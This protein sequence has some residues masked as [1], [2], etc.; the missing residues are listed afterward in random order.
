MTDW[1][2]LCLAVSIVNATCLRWGILFLGEPIVLGALLGLFLNNFTTGLYLGGIL[3]FMWLKS[4]PVGVKVQS[5][6]TVMTFLT[7][8][9]IGRFGERS[10]P[11][12]F[13]AAFAFSFLGK[14][15][16]TL[17]RRL[18]N[19]LADRVM[20]NIGRVN[21][22]LVNAVYLAGYVLV[23]AG[24]LFAGLSVSVPLVNWGLHWLPPKLLD[25]FQFSYPYLVLY[26]LSLFFQAV[27]L[28]GKLVYF[29]LGIAAGLCLMAF[30]FSMITNINVLVLLAAALSLINSKLVQFTGRKNAS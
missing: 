18:D 10:Y 23:F 6:Y 25:A 11:L 22:G 8:M 29:G 26:A 24:L 19:I 14:H 2:L 17:L 3:Q 15:L 20:N 7:I 1:L 28:N 21:L 30:N 12:V 16:E 5:N 9:L 4:I 13:A 27:S